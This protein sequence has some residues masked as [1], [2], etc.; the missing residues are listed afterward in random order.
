MARRTGGNSNIISCHPSR[1]QGLI[2][3]VGCSFFDPPN[4]IGVGAFLLVRTEQDGEKDIIQDPPNIIGLGAFLRV[5][6]E[7][8]GEKDI[9]PEPGFAAKNMIRRTATGLYSTFYWLCHGLSIRWYMFSCVHLV[10]QVL[11]DYPG[12]EAF[13]R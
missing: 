1:L 10:Y 12:V 3:N 2:E 7:Q 6:T 8:D 9:I 11:Q 13:S 4:I 5:R